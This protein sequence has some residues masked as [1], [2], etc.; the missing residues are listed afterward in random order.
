MFQMRIQ[1]FAHHQVMT[2]ES[3]EH[4]AFYAKEFDLTLIASADGKMEARVEIRYPDEPEP[5]VEQVTLRVKPVD[6]GLVLLWCDGGAFEFTDF[7]ME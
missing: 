7:T 1:D 5:R 4:P 2:A 6:P 3:F